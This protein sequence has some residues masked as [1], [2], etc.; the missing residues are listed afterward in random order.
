MAAHFRKHCV[1][2]GIPQKCQ[3][4]RGAMTTF[5]KDTFS[6][7]LKPKRLQSNQIRRWH[8]H[9][10]S[11]HHNIEAAVAG[12]PST[13][14]GK[15]QLKCRGPKLA[16]LRERAAGGGRRFKAAWIRQELYEWWS[17]IRYAIDWKQMVNENRSRC[18]KKSLSRFPRSTLKYKVYQLIQQHAAASI[19]NG[20]PVQTLKQFTWWFKRWEEEYGLSMRAAHFERTACTNIQ[21]I[22]MVVQTRGRRVRPFNACC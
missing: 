11:S 1:M 9:W 19:L 14:S 18:L 17:S 22:Y 15:C 8:S 3:L 10:L 2:V 4:P 21:A 7:T 12:T 16:C 5:I 20:Q 13:S 6:V